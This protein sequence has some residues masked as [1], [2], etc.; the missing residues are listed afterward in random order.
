MDPQ[1]MLGIRAV[2]AG[3]CGCGSTFTRSQIYKPCAPRL[4][5]EEYLAYLLVTIGTRPSGT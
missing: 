4:I 5:G 1:G 3:M 2:F